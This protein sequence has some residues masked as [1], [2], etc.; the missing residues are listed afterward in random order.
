MYTPATCYFPSFLSQLWLTN[1]CNPKKHSRQSTEATLFTYE[2][3]SGDLEE[4]KNFPPPQSPDAIFDDL[5]TSSFPLDTQSEAVL[6]EATTAF[7]NLESSVSSIC[8]SLLDSISW[9]ANK[10][11]RYFAFLRLRN[12]RGYEDILW[13]IHNFAQKRPSDGK[14][15]SSYRPYVAQMCRRNMLR[16]FI[17]FFD[18]NSKMIEYTGNMRLLLPLLPGVSL[19]ILGTASTSFMRPPSLGPQKVP[20]ELGLESGSDIHLRNALILQSSPQ[21]IFFSSKRSV[22]LSITKFGRG[23]LTADYSNLL[24]KCKEGRV[25]HTWPIGMQRYDIPT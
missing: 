2:T 23:V 14:I 8:T 9:G 4:S 13:S 18:P 24:E 1:I 25:Q 19:Y 7:A 16:T 10:S 15:Y 6:H 11:T 20:I 17:E 22:A 3:S 21:R 12:S 5:F